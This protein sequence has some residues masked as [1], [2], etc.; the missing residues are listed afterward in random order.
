MRQKQ[1][2]LCYKILSSAKAKLCGPE[3]GICR[4]FSKAFGIIR[5]K[6][7]VLVMLSVL[8]VF[9]CA[10]PQREE[11]P[12]EMTTNMAIDKLASEISISLPLERDLKI[13]VVDL[14]GPNDNHTQ[15]ESF[16]S[17]KLITKLFVSGRFEKVL[18]RK[19]LQDLLIQQK[20][21]MEGY[22]D[23]DTVRSIC[24]KI[25]ID[26][27][28]MGFITD[29]GS[30]VDVN[31]RLIDT[32]GEILS[33]ADAQIDKDQVQSMLRGV[34]RATLTVAINPA[35]VEASVTTGDRVLKSVNGIAVFRDLP[36]GKRSVIVTAKGYEVVQE[37]IYLSC[38]GM[39]I[40]TLRGILSSA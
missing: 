17:E 5:L 30:R 12:L 18:E 4:P 3:M 28:V 2:M 11:K 33:V 7:H 22:F 36:Q 25:G 21:E 38:S 40:A 39:K 37:S 24:G 20:I 32:N 6:T 19:L 31:V 14:L 29:C 35:D 34:K 27:M 23:Q 15:L 8:M 16:V 13:A 1:S 9:G 10:G 26:A